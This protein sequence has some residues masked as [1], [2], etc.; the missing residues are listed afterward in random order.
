[1]QQ[2][3]LSRISR[4]LS[5]GATSAV[6]VLSAAG[7]ASAHPLSVNPASGT[8]T[9]REAL[10]A[11]ILRYEPFEDASAL[12]ALVDQ[13][14]VSWPGAGTFALGILDDDSDDEDESEVEVPDVDDDEADDTDDAAES[15]DKDDDEADDEDD[16]DA[17]EADHDDGDSDDEDESDDED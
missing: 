8:D 16:G 7:A 5:V 4:R 1:M 9:E 17:E 13:V 6:L 11:L 14:L 15:E 10:A 2:D 12:Y 3:R